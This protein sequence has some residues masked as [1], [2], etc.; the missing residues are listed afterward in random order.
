MAAVP[1]PSDGDEPDTLAF[2]IAALDDR[3]R[4]SELSFP[5]RRDAL[6]ETL[7]DPDVPVDPSGRTIALSTAIDR[8]DRDRFEHRRDLLNALHP[9][10]ETER[11][12]GGGVRSLL[13]RLVPF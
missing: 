12:A 3:L 1:P 10:F 2:G 4:D 9:V 6:V 7:G 13:R 8:A 5:I 11:G